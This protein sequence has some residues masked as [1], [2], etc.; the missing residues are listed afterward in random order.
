MFFL[1]LIRWQNLLLIVFTQYVMRYC[2]I[3]PMLVI[4]N[5][6]L[7][8]SNLDFGMLVLSCVLIAAAGYII[9]DYFDTRI[10]A[11]NKPN[12]V[13]I[14]IHVKRRVA[15]LYHTVFNVIAVALAIW[16]SY[17]VGNIRFSII[18]LIATGTLWFYSTNFKKQVLVGNLLVAMLAAIIPLLVGVYE[19]SLLNNTYKADLLQYQFSF[20]YIAYFILSFSLFAFAL[21]L[22]REIIK[23]TEDISGDKEYGAETLPIYIGVKPTKWIVSILI[24]VTMLGIAYIQYMQFMAKDMLSIYY[25]LLTVQ[26]GLLAVLVLFWKANTKKGLHTI[27]TI[28]KLI[29][30][31][32]ICYAFIIRYELTSEVFNKKQTQEEL[33]QL[34]INGGF[35][36]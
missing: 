24:I 25:I 19:I 26:L 14:G 33:P 6:K 15:M 9:N 7:Q 27:S 28:I 12:Q 8:M 17:K 23:D 21:T 13:I 32:G 29:M 18:F 36:H 1:K 35:N 11:I 16:V 22:I 34:Q 5:Y 4:N 3:Q 10:D 20:N 31:A 2:I 30:L